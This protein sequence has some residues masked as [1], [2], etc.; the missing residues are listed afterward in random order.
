M[1]VLSPPPCAISRLRKPYGINMGAPK[2]T[3]QLY[4]HVHVA[5]ALL[6]SRYVTFC[7]VPFCG[8]LFCYSML[9]DPTLPSV[10]F[11]WFMSCFEPWRLFALKELRQEAA[12]E[13]R[14]PK[15][16]IAGPQGTALKAFL[17]PA[18]T[19]PRKRGSFGQSYAEKRDRWGTLNQ[20]TKAWP[21]S[22]W[23]TNSASWPPT[24]P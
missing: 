20:A 16:S 15:L 9:C 10:L 3:S 11:C 18:P 13:P 5:L 22:E 6:P 12:H 23:V 2:C 14:Q 8:A 21:D 7:S 24:S 1:H 19:G 17:S 4:T